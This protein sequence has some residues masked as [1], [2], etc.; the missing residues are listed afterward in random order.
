MGVTADATKLGPESPLPGPG[1]EGAR[2]RSAWEGEGPRTRRIDRARKLRRESTQAELKLWGALRSRQ[3]DGLKWRRQVPVDIYF[4]DFVSKEARLVVE[5][6]GESHLHRAGY[7]EARTRIIEAC[8][9][10]VIR[11]TNDEVVADLDNVLTRI[12]AEVR[13]ARGSGPSPSHS[14]APS[15]PLPLPGPGEEKIGGDHG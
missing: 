3:L 10:K 4:A 2:A 11:F 13:A 6:D 8:G 5:L 7:D 14:A 15:G 1:E 12:P 9:Y